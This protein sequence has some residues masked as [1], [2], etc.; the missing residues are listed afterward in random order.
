M[1][2]TSKD[3]SIRFKDDGHGSD[4]PEISRNALSQLLLSSVPSQLIKWETKVL[5][6]LPSSGTKSW[7]ITYRTQ[8]GRGQSEE[9]DLVIGADGAWS[10]T[11]LAIK[12]AEKPFYSGISCI[13]LTIPHLSTRY[14]ELEEKV[15]KG[16][17]YGLGG[18]KGLISQRGSID[19]ARMYLM[20]SAK[21]EGFLKENG[22]EGRS[23]EE[24]KAKLLE[25]ESLFASWGEKLKAL[26]AAGCDSEKGVVE[27]RPLYMLPIGNTWTHTPGLTL[28]GDAAHLMTPFAGEGVNCAMLDALELAQAILETVT[29]E[30]KGTDGLDEAVRGFEKQ[31]WE[32]SQ[33]I[34]QGTYDNLKTMF[35]DENAPEAF[36]KFFESMGPPPEE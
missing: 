4:R 11:R 3:G 31:M 2:I 22:L 6:V 14:P 35:H 26:I 36:V 33:E 5:S 1:I 20:I 21:E 15:G 9:F 34:A 32:R 16:S 27:A 10:K 28:V 13:T 25:E 19:S 29:G 30:G 12:G 7:S 23:G 24:L 17:F 18:G 8:E